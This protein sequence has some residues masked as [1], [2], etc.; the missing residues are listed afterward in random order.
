MVD[1]GYTKNKSNKRLPVASVFTLFM[2][3]QKSDTA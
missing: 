2:M 1:G 3:I